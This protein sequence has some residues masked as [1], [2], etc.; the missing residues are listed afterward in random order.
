MYD[1]G[2]VDGM[3][4]ALGQIASA[5]G[6][7]ALL[8]GLALGTAAAVLPG[9][10]GSTVM[11]LA[12]PLLF[13]LDKYTALLFIA[14]VDGAGGFAGSMTSIL[15]NVP[16]DSANAATCLDGHPLAKRG[17]AGVA[18][19]AAATSSAFGGVIGVAVVLIGLPIMG[20]L[21]LS[22]GP[23]EFFA[24]TVAGV[25]LIGTVSTGSPIRGIIAGLL[26]MVIGFI[27]ANPVGGGLRYTFGVLDLYDGVN[28]V[29]ALIGLF[30]VPELYE[31]LTSN[32]AISRNPPVAR[33]VRE[34]VV[35]VLQRPALLVRSSL[36]G[37]FTGLLP[38]VGQVLAAWMSYF[39]AAKTSKSPETFGK[40]NIEGVIAPEATMNAK[41]STSVLP[42]FIF[43]LPS[44]VTM[45]IYLSVFQIFG[46]V[47]GAPLL[48]DDPTLIWV[49]VFALAIVSI[50]TSLM[51]IAFA[52]QMVKLTL[53]PI[54][55]L[56]PVIY[57]LGLIGAYVSSNTLFSVAV[58]MG[59]GVLGIVMDRL[60]YP[61]A[62]LLVG[63]V[64][65]P[66]AEQN[67]FQA[68][69]IHR[70]SYEWLYTRPIATAVLALV[71]LVFLFPLL[72][73]RLARSAP[74]SA[75]AIGEAE[76]LSR[77]AVTGSADARPLAQVLFA[78]ALLAVTA[79]FLSQATGFRPNGREFPIIVESALAIALG[80]VVLRSGRSLLVR[81]GDRSS[82]EGVGDIVRSSRRPLL[83]TGW[84]L[85]F[86]AG[87]WVFGVFV[88]SGLYI[89]AFVA[90]FAPS[91]FTRGRAVAAMLLSAGVVGLL[92]VVFDRLLQLPLYQGLFV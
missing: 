91:E 29:A 75:G 65:L 40:G 54:A 3:A 30:L 61:R 83:V 11:V 72:R 10:S 47:P 85:A 20:G 19:G 21:I 16:G 27:G 74:V 67:F 51:G 36:L 64:L 18:I 80:I 55:L 23:P 69:Q 63:F 50:A 66:F 15:L 68:V 6:A 59:F 86:P 39:L 56:A 42:L 49:I 2:V 45:A 48:R 77:L 14:A 8:L 90:A 78:G 41:E 35:A 87:M 53:V 57:V 4:E 22:F 31:W 26:G 81:R 76:A 13:T 79:V 62:A 92:Y 73:R 24:L 43:G 34:G 25:A 70:G 46:I 1:R 44:G 89:A 52:N 71:A 88:A 9:I 33:G 7:A 5:H 60:Q 12:L 84:L 17:K 82:R 28:L 58:A 37:A 32:E 38:G